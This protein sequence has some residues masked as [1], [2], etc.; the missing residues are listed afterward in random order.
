HASGR[1]RVGQLGAAVG[2]RA[3]GR[4]AGAAPGA[5]H[6]R[7]GA[8]PRRCPAAGHTGVT[9]TIA[10]RPQLPSTAARRMLPLVLAGA[11]VLTALA[12]PLSS[13]PARDTVSWTIG[14]LG[15]LL[16]VVH[17]GFSRGARAGAG[18][19]VLVA[20]TSV[21]FEAVGL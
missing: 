21:A 3:R 6:R 8:P 15:A 5:G 7:P 11:L 9:A 1:G 18:L 10:A 16:S 12:Y 4:R 17:A 14:L 19:L 20:L 2:P 13:G